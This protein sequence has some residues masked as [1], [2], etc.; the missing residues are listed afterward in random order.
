MPK[1]CDSQNTVADIMHGS[2]NYT[3]FVFILNGHLLGNIW[4]KYVESFD[5][6]M[7]KKSNVTSYCVFA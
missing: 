6:I 7:N 1:D 2:D 4:Y 3:A 5:R